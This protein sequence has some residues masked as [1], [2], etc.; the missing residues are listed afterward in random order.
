MHVHVAPLQVSGCI[1]SRADVDGYGGDTRMRR[2][3]ALEP[4]ILYRHASPAGDPR[5]RDLHNRHYQQDEERNP[6]GWDTQLEPFRTD[7]VH[8]P[9][10]LSSAVRVSQIKVC[11]VAPPRFVINAFLTTCQP[12]VRKLQ[13]R[14]QPACR[15]GRIG[16]FPRDRRRPGG[17]RVVR[18]DDRRAGHVA[19]LKA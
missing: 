6:R 8:T 14:S 12:L 10:K 17:S 16:T 18:E 15:F 19:D 11:A 4:R 1:K 2:Q 3:S 5:H 13:A 9:W 7:R